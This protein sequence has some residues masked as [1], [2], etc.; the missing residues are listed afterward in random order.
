[1]TCM[2]HSAVALRMVCDSFPQFLSFRRHPENL[3]VIQ[4]LHACSGK[5][6]LSLL[7]FL[8][9]ALKCLF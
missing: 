9:Q 5:P 2:S 4:V 3:C 1:M 8:R 6:G 7:P